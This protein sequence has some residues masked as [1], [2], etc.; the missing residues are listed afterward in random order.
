[1]ITDTFIR[2]SHLAA[3]IPLIIVM[4]G[5]LTFPILA[6][7]HVDYMGRLVATWTAVLSC[8]TVSCFFVT[9][10]LFILVIRKKISAWILG[11]PLSLISGSYGAKEIVR[12]IARNS[13]V[14]KTSL[15]WAI[16]CLIIF[17]LSFLFFL[18]CCCR[19]GMKRNKNKEKQV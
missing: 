12:Y 11:V 9:L 19:V 8:I 13:L 17:F 6:E 14:E 5:I 2:R 3:V 4:A 7:A 10:V 15:S 1:M 18:V 16:F